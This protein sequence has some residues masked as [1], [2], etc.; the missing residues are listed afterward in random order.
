MMRPIDLAKIGQMALDE[1]VWDGR[2][3]I[4][5]KWLE[6]SVK[7][8]Q[9]FEADY[10]LLWRINDREGERV[11]G[12]TPALVERWV[13]AGVRPEIIELLRPL[14]GRPMKNLDE[15]GES[16]WTAYRD[17]PAYWE[18]LNSKWR[19]GLP[20]REIIQL[21]PVDGFYAVGY[22]GQYLVVDPKRRLVGV[23]MRE[24]NDNDWHD[25][26]SVDVF[27]DFPQLVPRL[28]P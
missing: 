23:R 16:L 17:Y 1:G 7:T 19:R 12:V 14:I 15:L 6:E 8:A 10:G 4:N 26:P 28:V 11:V 25:R 5:Q 9:S 3:I 13:K 18:E 21:G 24:A 27:W 22:L 20:F 2:R